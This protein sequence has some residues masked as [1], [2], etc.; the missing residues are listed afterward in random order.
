MA[1]T[2]KIIIYGKHEMKT[3]YYRIH[4]IDLEDRVTEWKEEKFEDIKS[5]WTKYANLMDEHSV[6]G[7]LELYRIIDDELGEDGR[8]MI[9][10]MVRRD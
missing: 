7:K 8:E 5:I 6:K 9:F 2:E 10:M 3:P 1:E 4:F